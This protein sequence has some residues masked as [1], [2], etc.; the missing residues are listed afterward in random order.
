MYLWN[1]RLWLLAEVL[2]AVDLRPLY[3]SKQTYRRP[4]S[5]PGTKSDHLQSGDRRL[6]V[7]LSGH[8]NLSEGTRVSVS[9]NIVLK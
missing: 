9:F 7:T 2:G 8:P 3:P 4:M 5:A 1:V 6:L